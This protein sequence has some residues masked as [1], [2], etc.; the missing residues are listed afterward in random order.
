[1][2]SSQV[3]AEM[4]TAQKALLFTRM[5]E[6]VDQAT[7]GITVRGRPLTVNELVGELSA[8][9]KAPVF[10]GSGPGVAALGVASRCHRHDFIIFGDIHGSPKMFA[11]TVGPKSNLTRQVDE[12]FKMPESLTLK[13]V[14]QGA[15]WRKKMKGWGYSVRSKADGFGKVVITLERHGR[16]LTLV[17]GNTVPYTNAIGPGACLD[18]FMLQDLRAAGALIENRQ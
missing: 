8:V 3:L 18:P 9:A 17:Q 10:A 4:S 14:S 2:A 11:P 13:V 15:Q 6:L 7:L 5:C 1:M 12:L 16:S